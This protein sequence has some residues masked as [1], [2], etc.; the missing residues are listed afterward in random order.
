MVKIRNGE[1]YVDVAFGQIKK[2]EWYPTNGDVDVI[3]V[4]DTVND[5]SGRKIQNIFCT[6]DD[7]NDSFIAVDAN[8]RVIRQYIGGEFLIHYFGI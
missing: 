6:S 2:L 3:T 7:T 4:G 5:N 8:G 1:G